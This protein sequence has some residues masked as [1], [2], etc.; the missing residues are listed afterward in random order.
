M[1]SVL[2]LYK[3]VS[4]YSID[5]IRGID[6]KV[7]SHRIHLEEDSRPTREGQGRLN[8]AMQEVVKKEVLKL[9]QAGMIYPISDSEWVSPIHIVPKKGGYTVMENEEGKLMTTRPVTGWRMVNDFRK[10]NKATRKDHFPMPFMDQM[11]E[12]LAGQAYYCYL[13]G[14]SG[15]LQ[16][17]I[18]PSDQDK[19]TFTCPYGTF[20]YKRLPF[21]LCNAPG[22]FQR[23]MLSIFS[24]HVEKIMEVFMDDFTV[25][26][27]DFENC[28]KI[29]TAVLHRCSEQNLI[30]NWEK[31]HFL[32]TEGIVLGHMVSA[33]GI[34]VDKAKVDV[35]AKLPPPEN[36]KGIQSFLGHAGFYRRFI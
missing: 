20:A 8:P 7:C 30:L 28:L 18:H 13:D 1:L 16:I 5:D 19:T 17:P 35:I 2:R 22:T 6:E 26:G 29:L 3:N 11:L 23:C 12:R 33:R 21:G 9:L 32:V 27:K 4:G 14:Y 25:Y 31:R 24:D 34:E 36:L 15:F 10:L